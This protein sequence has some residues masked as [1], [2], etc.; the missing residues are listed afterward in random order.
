M[1]REVISEK[2]KTKIYKYPSKQGK[3][4]VTYYI[5]NDLVYFDFINTD[6][7]RTDEMYVE[8]YK[9]DPELSI[10]NYLKAINY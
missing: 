7:V 9:N 3:I 2:R 5:Q 1:F 6:G 10:F 4:D 8:L